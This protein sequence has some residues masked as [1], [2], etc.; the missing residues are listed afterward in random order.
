MKVCDCTSLEFSKV[1]H[2]QF[3]QDKDNS[4]PELL[5]WFR[6]MLWMA[7]QAMLIRQSCWKEP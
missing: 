3:L 1:Q 4:K 6:V 5:C 2:K 7:T